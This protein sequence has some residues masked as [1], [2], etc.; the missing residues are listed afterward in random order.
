MALLQRLI[1]FVY[2]N[3]ED[4]TLLLNRTEGLGGEPV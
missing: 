3:R 2:A 4:F 1:D